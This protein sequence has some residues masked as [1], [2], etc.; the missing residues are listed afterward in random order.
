MDPQG[1]VRWTYEPVRRSESDGFRLVGSLPARR[2]ATC[3][4]LTRLTTYPIRGWLTPNS[5]ARA[6]CVAPSA[7]RARIARTLSS[8]N[9]ASGRA[10]P[11][12]LVSGWLAGPLLPL[13]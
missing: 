2:H 1:G 4:Q 5:A 11:R 3:F 9:L 12:F 7:C 6:V 13:E 8:V 10:S